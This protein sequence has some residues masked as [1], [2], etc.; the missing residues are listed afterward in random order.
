MIAS[1]AQLPDFRMRK[2][3]ENEN[4]LWTRFL[5]FLRFSRITHVDLK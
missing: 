3:C 5:R 1:R 4:E 2:F